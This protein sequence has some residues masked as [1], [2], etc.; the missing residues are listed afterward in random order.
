MDDDWVVLCQ[1]LYHSIG[2]E[3]WTGMHDN[4][5]EVCR[6]IGVK[7]AEQRVA[8]LAL[9]WSTG[10]RKGFGE[11]LALQSNPIASVFDSVAV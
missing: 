5:T 4:V 3:E 6:K 1:A 7:K 8:G 9:V 2:E 11:R 10:D